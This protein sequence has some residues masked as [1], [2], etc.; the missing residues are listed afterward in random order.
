MITFATVAGLV[1]GLI[2]AGLYFG[3]RSLL[4]F[5]DRTV[6][7]PA[8]YGVAYAM[9]TVRYDTEDGLALS[10]WYRPADRDDRATVVYF[11]GNGGHHGHRG[12]TVRYLWESGYGVLLAGYRGYGGN[13]GSPSETGLA[14]DARAAL[15]WLADQG[16]GSDC[17]VLYGES[18]GSGVAIRLGSETDVAAVL[19]ESPFSSIADVGQAHYPVFPV[20]LLLRDRFDSTSR[21]A[22]IGAPILVMHGDADRTVPIRFGRRL[23]EAAAEPKQA[24]WVPGG[25]HVDL[26]RYGAAGVVLEFLGQHAAGCTPADAHE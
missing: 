7:D 24:W 16:V 1:Y 25:G 12:P 13:P 17:I 15:R 2:V 20:R 23:F 21:V 6:P 19:L 9:T 4:Y 26:H 18:L 22:D 3:Q 5:P 11:H 10:A 14:A 8:Q